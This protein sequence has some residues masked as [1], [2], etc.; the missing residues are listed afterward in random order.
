MEIVD[1]KDEIFGHMKIINKDNMSLLSACLCSVGVFENPLLREK[2]TGEEYDI[3]WINSLIIRSNELLGD[4]LIKCPTCPSS[5][6]RQVQKWKR[7]A[8]FA[9]V[10]CNYINEK[11]NLFEDL[12]RDIY[13]I[14]FFPKIIDRYDEHIFVK[15]FNIL[16]E[17]FSKIKYYIEIFNREHSM[18][19]NDGLTDL[20]H[21]L[22][23]EYN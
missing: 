11:I 17:L 2:E 5:Q 1:L 10:R 19:I 18:F 12:I 22:L 20:H 14:A 9:T 13:R 4:D 6:K 8:Y 7:Y 21:K 3:D 23:F 15:L 16:L